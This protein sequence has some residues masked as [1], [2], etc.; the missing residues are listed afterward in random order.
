V[1]NGSTAA[2]GLLVAPSTASITGNFTVLPDNAATNALVTVAR[3]GVNSTGTGATGLGPEVEFSAETSTT[4]DRL[5][6]SIAALTTDGTDATRT[7]AVVVKTV[8]SAG[9]NTERLR[10]TAGGITIN[11]GATIS[12]VLT[13][14]ATLDFGNTLAQTDS[15]LTITVT[16]AVDGNPCIV[17]PP[18]GS[19]Q[20]GSVYSCWVSAAD[21]V[22]VRFSVYG[23]TAKDPASGTFRVTLLQH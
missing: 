9:T 2:G 15:D 14:T 19:T 22:T 7:G 8:N 23:L 1:R 20:T 13:N 3:F 18:N 10:V 17:G 11:S 5:L 4:N 21:T 16:G 12:K 6:G